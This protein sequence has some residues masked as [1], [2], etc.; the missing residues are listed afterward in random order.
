MKYHC[1]CAGLHGKDDLRYRPVLEAVDQF[2][3]KGVGLAHGF[4][5]RID[6]CVVGAVNMNRPLGTVDNGE[7]PRPAVG[8]DKRISGIAIDDLP[9]GWRG[10]N[11]QPASLDGG[12]AVKR[13]RIRDGFTGR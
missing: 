4:D 8:I 11:D 10:F 7:Q 1:L 13:G 3:G 2:I 6:G 5:E 9:P 12:D